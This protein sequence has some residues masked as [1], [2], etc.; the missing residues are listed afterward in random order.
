MILLDTRDNMPLSSAALARVGV[1][2]GPEE[3]ERLLE[4]VLLEMLPVQQNPAPGH[5]LTAQEL[6][7]LQEAGVSLAPPELDA[8]SPLVRAA[9]EYAAL[10]GSSFSVREAAAHLGIHPSRVRQRLL[11][12]TLYGIKHAHEWRLPQFQ[13]TTYGLVPGFVRV[14]P[15]LRDEHPVAAA[16]WFTL[17]HS[18]LTL[19]EDEERPIS[20]R[21][22]L[23]TGHDP[24]VVVQ[25]A[26]ELQ[27]IA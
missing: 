10:L 3:L 9:A 27:D 15:H 5:E 18:D 24:E 6:G 1:K 25:L 11:A 7:V 8:D 26:R 14:V 19:G 4:E 12:R 22:W 23:I 16:R 20:P 2:A 17:P 13:F 21:E